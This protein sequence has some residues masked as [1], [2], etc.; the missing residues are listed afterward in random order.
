M[1]QWDNIVYS[2][3]IE[4]KQRIAQYNREASASLPIDQQHIS[5]TTTKVINRRTGSTRE[6]KHWS[7]AQINANRRAACVAKYWVKT[8]HSNSLNIEFRAVQSDRKC[9]MDI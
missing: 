4:Q 2:N 6:G 3:A 9:I 1:S 5:T 7:I 8:P